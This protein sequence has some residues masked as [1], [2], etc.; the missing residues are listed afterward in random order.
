MNRRQFLATVST[1]TALGL[2][3]CG[4][5]GTETVGGGDGG[6][7]DTATQSPTPTPADSGTGGSTP[8]QTPTETPTD[9]PTETPSPTPSPTPAG[10]PNV[11]IVESE[12]VVEEGQW[13]TDT[14]VAAT[15][16]NQGDAPSGQITLTAE[17]YDSNGDF[18][19]NANQYLPILRAGETWE[20]HVHAL[21]DAEK[22]E[23]YDLS[24]EYESTPA[25]PPENVEI[26]ETSH[27]V[28][29]D[30]GV[31]VTGRVANNTGEEIN[32][33]EA[34]ALLYDDS[35]VVLSGDWTNQ[36]GIPKDETWRFEI[37]WFQFDR[38]ERVADHNVILT[39]N[40]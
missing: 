32:Y 7:E 28:S 25:R 30:G 19:D 18:L 16:E 37:E 5:G 6:V 26:V 35:G 36:S 22:I 38:A 17:W 9:T 15:V 3:G 8:T 11:Q 1:T 31:T 14:Y 33:L 20:A 24:G 27:E 39:T 29:D 12:L 4:D 23:D 40:F 2:A 13:S 10:E 34:E 21:S